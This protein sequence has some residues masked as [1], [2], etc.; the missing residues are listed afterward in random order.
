M[1]KTKRAEYLNFA[2]GDRVCVVRG[3]EKGKIGRVENVDEESQSLTVEGVN[4]VRLGP[5]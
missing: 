2:S 4:Q 5:S 3:R 1:E